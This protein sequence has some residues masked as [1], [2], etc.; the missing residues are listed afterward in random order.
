VT[1]GVP[2]WFSQVPHRLIVRVLVT[3]TCLVVLLNTY[4]LLIPWLP[5]DLRVLG[6]PMF[7]SQSLAQRPIQVAVP[8]RTTERS[9]PVRCADFPS[10]AAAQAYYRDDQVG[11]ARLDG[12]GDGVACQN[13]PAP[14]DWM[15]VEH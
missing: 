10:Q 12:N 15:P 5:V 1:I 2:M 9:A 11:A 4:L 8:Q 3:I 14:H 13:N 7:R 6:E